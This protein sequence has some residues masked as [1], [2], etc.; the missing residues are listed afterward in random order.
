MKEKALT[1][2]E[3]LFCTYYSIKRS[4]AEAAFKAGYSVMPERAA[5]KLLRKESVKNRI[6]ALSKENRASRN[7]VE[8]GL[9]RIAF[10]CVADAVKIAL[11]EDF[12]VEEL[13]NMDLFGISE[14]KVSRGKGVE[15][16]FFDRIKAL[17]KLSLL[18]KED[19]DSSTDS[20]FRAIEEGAEALRAGR[21][22]DKR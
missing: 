3:N 21:D 17:E 22:E 8:A 19:A 7:E 20:L 12:N 18:I 5:M 2:K 15:I 10:G 1:Q 9:R 13:R 14:I 6:A 16:K 4:A 11:S